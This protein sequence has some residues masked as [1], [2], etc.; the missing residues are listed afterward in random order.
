V[1]A[2]TKV[3]IKCEYKLYASYQMVSFPKIL[4]S[5]TW[6]SRPRYFTKANV[7]FDFIYGRFL[8]VHSHSLTYYIYGQWFTMFLY[9]F[10]ILFK[11]YTLCILLQNIIQYDEIK[12]DWFFKASLINDLVNVSVCSISHCFAF[13]IFSISFHFVDVEMFSLFEQLVIF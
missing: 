6:I 7:A 8:N 12:L 9:H 2:S 13:M 4:N 5:F 10:F 3:T 1:Q 11:E